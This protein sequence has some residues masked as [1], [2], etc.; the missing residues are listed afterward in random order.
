MKSKSLCDYDDAE[1]K[2]RESPDLNTLRMTASSYNDRVLR[3]K[4]CEDKKL[5]S[6][7]QAYYNAI[8]STSE[9]PDANI[10]VMPAYAQDEVRQRYEKAMKPWEKAG[11]FRG[12]ED[13]LKNAWNETWNTFTEIIDEI[14]Q[15]LENDGYDAACKGN[16]IIR[17]EGTNYTFEDKDVVT[18][19]KVRFNDVQININGI[20]RLHAIIRIFGNKIVV[21]DVGSYFGIKCLERAEDLPKE[22]S[23]NGARKP[24]V[25]GVDETVI[26]KIGFEE[27]II[28][29]K[30]CVICLENTRSFVGNCGHFTMCGD[31]AEEVLDRC[32]LCPICRQILRGD[33]MKINVDRTRTQLSK[34][35]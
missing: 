9:K 18:I 5:T 20:S 12:D 16:F 15:A 6:I 25:F 32:G 29:P 28:S 22:E 14:S 2:F 35:K 30:Q 8:V 21:M 26:L 7:S 17:H 33:N 27:I 1:S 4:T 24:L 23:V 31:C 11:K 19:G 34:L 13:V 10:D 3:F